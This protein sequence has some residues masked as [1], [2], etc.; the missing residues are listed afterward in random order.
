MQQIKIIRELLGMLP[1][2]LRKKGNS[3]LFCIVFRSLLDLLGIAGVLSVVYFLIREEY[4]DYALWI[5]SACAAV[6]VLK[7]VVQHSV[8]RHCLK[9]YMSLFKYYSKQ[10]LDNYFNAGLLYIRNNGVSNLTYHTNSLCH[11]FATVVIPTIMQSIGHSIM[12]FVF[13]VCFFVYSPLIAGLFT[14][15][16]LLFMLFYMRFSGSGMKEV[17]RKETEVKK[18]QWA[19]TENIYKGYAELKVY[20]SFPYFEEQFVNGIDG[21]T[22][23]RLMMK[24]QSE[25]PGYITELI[26][27]LLLGII[28]IISNGTEELVLLLGAFTLAVFKILPSARHLISGFNTI[29]NTNIAS[30]IIYKAMKLH[31]PF[32][33]REENITLNESI[34]FDD[35]HFAYTSGT[36]IIKGVDMSIEKG[37]QVGIE[38]VSG[39]GKTTLLN[40]LLGFLCPS[41]GSIRID[42]RDLADADLSSWY[43]SVGYVPQEV[44]VADESIAANIALGINSDDWDME[45]INQ[46]LET[47]HLADWVR[48][49]PAGVLT[50]IGENGCLMSVGQKQRIGIA[51]ALY[52]NASVLLL[53]EA[54]SSLDEATERE[55]LNIVSALASSDTDRTLIMIS[56]H[57][58]ALS[59]CRRI[60]DLNHI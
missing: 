19:V 10:V 7:M 27:L 4:M 22:S 26:M 23:Y 59:I 58:R 53:D 11:S 16:L 31:S 33:I 56:H 37:E 49:L 20:D 9:W 5:I 46:V 40:L 24:T 2:S 1:P 44:F 15:S 54:T 21:I 51:R 30:E 36:P 28:L 41:Q 35:V 42:G 55:I 29:R 8:D 25:I 17:G 47:V 13:L 50:R 12:V 43:K 34:V 45:R 48:K 60:I 6:L 52:K 3:V 18:R 32:K 39:L 14:F 57:Q 38:G